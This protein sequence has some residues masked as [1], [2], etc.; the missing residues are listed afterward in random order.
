MNF[1]TKNLGW[2]LLLLFFLFMLFIIS[3]NENTPTKN[4]SWSSIEVSE[5]KEAQENLDSLVEMIN[6][7]ETGS[8]VLISDETMMKEDDNKKKKSLFGFLFGKSSKEPQEPSSSDEIEQTNE[9]NISEILSDEVDTEKSESLLSKIFTRKG[10]DDSD[11]PDEEESTQSGEI[12]VVKENK[13]SVDRDT[14]IWAAWS[15]NVSNTKN[16]MKASGVKHSIAYADIRKYAP[17]VLGESSMYPW[18]NLET[19]IGKSFEIGVHS[20]KLNNK[21]FNETLAYIMRGDTVKQL[22]EENKYGCFEVEIT[23]SVLDA[24]QGKKWYVCKKYLQDI[25]SSE[26]TSEEVLSDNDTNVNESI[27]ITT[28]IWDLIE[29]KKDGVVVGDAILS[30]GDLIDQMTSGGSECFTGRVYQSNTAEIMGVVG[31]VCAA[32]LY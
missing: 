32:N 15:S 21:Y 14:L 13:V 3:S 19:K 26:D 1:V 25:P 4:S 11:E 9:E 30:K 6:E 28:K 29:V 20:L 5:T 22:T 24:N 18:I 27:V 7:D 31:L 10:Q 17:E 12:M 8:W 16:V 2:I 23:Q